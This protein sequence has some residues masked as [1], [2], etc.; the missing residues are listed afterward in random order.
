MFFNDEPACEPEPEPSREVVGAAEPELDVK[1]CRLRAQHL[2]ALVVAALCTG[3]RRKLTREERYVML[4]PEAALAEARLPR[5]PD[6]CFF[7][8]L[9]VSHTSLSAVQ[10]CHTFWGTQ[11]LYVDMRCRNSPF[12]SPASPRYNVIWWC[13]G[14]PHSLFLPQSPGSWMIP[15]DSMFNHMT[16]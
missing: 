9:P 1:Y 3:F 16:S 6:T 14:P 13:C 4:E 12:A 10:R 2:D 8:R 15:M 11:I 7:S 5:R